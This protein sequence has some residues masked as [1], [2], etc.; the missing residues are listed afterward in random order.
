MKYQMTYLEEEIKDLYYSL[1]IKSPSDIDMY[2]IAN[3]FDVWIHYHKN[4]SIVLK[5]PNG[6]YSIFL[7]ER[8]SYQEQWEDFGHEFGHV[9]KHVG[10]QFKME[11]M[12]RQLQENQANNFMYH[13]CVP[14]FMLL[15]YNIANFYN[16]NDGIAF[17]TSTFNVT[18]QFA[19]KRL[20][21]FRNQLQQAKAD[22]DHRR[23]MESLY[24][25]AQPY[26]KETKKILHKLNILLEKKQK[27][28]L[29]N[30]STKSL[31][32]IC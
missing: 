27:E 14:T 13:F 5:K 6:L 10:Y 31:P 9:L 26:S 21:Q 11:K 17:V 1:N 20:I 23:Y 2:H 16:I 18:E 29:S 19:R 12:F 15:N 28:L 4:E 3:E 32:R 24:P 25:K 8:L 22:E 30:A 7:D